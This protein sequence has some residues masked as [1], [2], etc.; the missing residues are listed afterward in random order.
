MWAKTH[1][2]IVAVSLAVVAVGFGAYRVLTA[3]PDQESPATPAVHHNDRDPGEVEQY[4][5]EE[6]MRNATGG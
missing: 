2:R 3:Q 6:R 1:T 4:W 5:T